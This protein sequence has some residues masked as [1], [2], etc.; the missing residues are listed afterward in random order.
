MKLATG[1]SLCG[2]DGGRVRWVSGTPGMPPEYAGTDFVVA[3]DGKIAALYVSRQTS[4]AAAGG[5][6]LRVRR[7]GRDGQCR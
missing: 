4:L 6:S 7:G 1:L 2:A 3:R 5:V